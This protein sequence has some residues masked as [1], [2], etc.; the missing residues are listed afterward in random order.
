VDE[1]SSKTATGF[2]FAEPSPEALAETIRRAMRVFATPE[3][4]QELQRNGMIQ[5]F[6]W[7]RSARQYVSLYRQLASARLPAST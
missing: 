7:D 1:R 4:W 5:N 3:R 6:S 2:L